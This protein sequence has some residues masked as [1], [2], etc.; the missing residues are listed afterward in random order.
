LV[1]TGRAGAAA[2]AGHDLLIRV[3]S[4]QATLS[5]GEGADD[6]S[7]ELVADGGSLEVLEG[8]GGVQGLGDDDKANI[9]KTIDDEILERRDIA[10]SS[11]RAEPGSEAGRLHIE[12]DLT[13]LGETKPV[14]FDLEL[15]EDGALTAGA[16]VKQTD[17]GIKPYTILFGALKVADEVEV[18]L[19]GHL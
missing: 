8:T 10:F 11:T 18:A 13:I 9:A 5:I 6:S 4:W 16:V 12:G 1:R 19:E 3:N 2:K 15:A 7:A 14:A 17:W